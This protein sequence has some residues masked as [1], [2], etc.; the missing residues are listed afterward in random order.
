LLKKL[1]NVS[2]KLGRFWRKAGQV[3]KKAGQ[4]LRILC[5][6]FRKEIVEIL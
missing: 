2:K 4:V 6:A 5:S 3:F 1:G